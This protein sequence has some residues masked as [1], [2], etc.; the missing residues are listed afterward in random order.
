[1]YQKTVAFHRVWD[2]H[3]VSRFLC[4]W[5]VSGCR[6]CSGRGRSVR[7]GSVCS[8]PTR[9]CTVWTLPFRS[10]AFPAGTSPSP[11][12]G[13]SPSPVFPSTGPPTWP[14]WWRASCWSPSGHF[15][16]TPGIRRSRL[17]SVWRRTCRSLERGSQSWQKSGRSCT[18]CWLSRMGP[19]QQTSAAPS[20]SFQR[21]D[22]KPFSQLG[23]L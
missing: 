4:R 1:M 5:C 11:A 13:E 8:F 21:N 2:Q 18:F 17:S 15:G 9:P 16:V 7:T 20:S 23:P 10:W 12:M 3:G 6:P 19:K 14:T 22:L